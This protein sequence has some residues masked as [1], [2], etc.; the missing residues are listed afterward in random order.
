MPG[1]PVIIMLTNKYK[2]NPIICY[3]LHVHFVGNLIH[4]NSLTTI[5]II[6]TCVQ[7]II[8]YMVQIDQVMLCTSYLC[9][10]LY[11]SRLALHNTMH[12]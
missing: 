12:S 9:V 7:V 11:S 6:E 3:E 10:E 1:S 5:L 8:V 2:P 4:L